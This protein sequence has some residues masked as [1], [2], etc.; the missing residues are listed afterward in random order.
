MPIEWEADAETGLILSAAIGEIPTEAYL[1]FWDEIIADPRIAPG[2]RI[3]ADF[4]RVEVTRSGADVRSLATGS[5]R[6]SE[7]MAG[8]RMAVVATQQASFGLA[9]M[10][11]SL[12]SALDIEVRV[13]RDHDEARAWA[14]D[15]TANAPSQ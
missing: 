10:Y 3:V 9:R 8:G 1:A 5:K 13:F 4:R 11:E 15:S 14:L 2:P 12:V 7:F 6:F